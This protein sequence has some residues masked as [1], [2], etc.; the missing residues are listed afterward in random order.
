MSTD[1]PLAGLLGELAASG[2]IDA[3]VALVGDRRRV[4]AAASVAAGRAWR[5]VDE[6]AR[7]DL[8]SLTK[9]VV[10]TLALALARRGLLPLDARVGDLLPCP[11]ARLRECTLEALLRHRSGLLPWTP[12]YARTVSAERAR[13]LLLSGELMAATRRRR[14]VYS[15][16][17]YL[18]W[19]FAAEAALGAPL[20]ELLALHVTGP[21]AMTG[22]EPAPGARSG[23]MPT[24]LGNHR[25]VELARAQGILVRRRRQLLHG[26][27]QDGNAR[28]LGGLAGHAGL[29]GDA[30]ALWRFAGEWLAP[31]RVLTPALVARA[32]DGSVREGPAERLALG[33][34]RR[35][36]RGHAGPALSPRAFG[37]VGFTGGSLWIDPERR[38]VAVLLAHRRDP[39]FELA[40]W[41]RRFHRLAVRLGERAAST[42]SPR[43]R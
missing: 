36:V 2:G 13:E 5:D 32:V 43:R 11:H 31:R 35:R 39:G 25:E 22:V 34:W 8:A 6:S 12:L 42:P 26:V 40:P 24:R 20:A 18:L 4:L 21:L 15:D 38:L 29:F 1:A 17:G 14:A 10:A 30:G 28:F 27:P 16:L 3:A 23:V 7:F 19:G 37:M 9:P 33:W 41:R